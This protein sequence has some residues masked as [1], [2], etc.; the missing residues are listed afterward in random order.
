MRF[1]KNS[2]PS[3][4]KGAGPAKQNNIMVVKEGDPIEEENTMAAFKRSAN[5]ETLTK[6][7]RMQNAINAYT[8]TQLKPKIAV[9][10]NSRLPGHS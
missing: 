8:K 9:R 4:A 7:Q 1:A 6:Q 10:M 2:E 3:K 5:G